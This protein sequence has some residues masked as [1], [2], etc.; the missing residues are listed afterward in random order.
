MKYTVEDIR[1]LN[2]RHPYPCERLEALLGDGLMLLEI[3][4][5]ALPIK[6]RLWSMVYLLSEHHVRL[7]TC[8]CAY[9]VLPRFERVYPDDPRPRNAIEVAVKYAKGG[10]TKDELDAA[11]AGALTSV[12]DSWTHGVGPHHDV[13]WALSIPA[14]WSTFWATNCAET[15]DKMWTMIS[16]SLHGITHASTYTTIY[17]IQLRWIAARLDDGL[18]E[19]SISF[20]C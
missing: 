15:R 8:A 20:P 11:Y 10:A 2:P 14:I 18:W 12:Q 16:F 13:P 1:S 17:N 6:D 19:E 7:F 3:C 4:E 5:L 9:S